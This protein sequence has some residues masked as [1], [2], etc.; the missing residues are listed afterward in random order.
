M[1]E[2]EGW[3]EERSRREGGSK[4]EGK[5]GGGDRGREREKKILSTARCLQR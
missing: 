4:D 5:E 1:G 3:I 2:G